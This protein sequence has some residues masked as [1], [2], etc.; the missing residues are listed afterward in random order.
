M[1]TQALPLITALMVEIKKDFGRGGGGGLPSSTAG[2]MSEQENNCVKFLQSFI[3]KI[4]AGLKKVPSTLCT[5]LHL[6][7]LFFYKQMYTC[8]FTS[9]SYKYM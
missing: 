9:A 4:K 5:T 2:P 7:K 1:E 3:V 6:Y 8:L